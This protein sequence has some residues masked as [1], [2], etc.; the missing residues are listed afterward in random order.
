MTAEVSIDRLMSALFT[1]GPPSGIQL[2]PDSQK[3]VAWATHAAT[4]A[5]VREIG[6]D[7]AIMKA[8][9]ALI[10]TCV[11]VRSTDAYDVGQG[12]RICRALH[13]G[14]IVARVSRHPRAGTFRS[15]IEAIN[16]GRATLAQ[17]RLAGRLAAEV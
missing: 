14:W 5:L 1:F 11:A 16:R 6:D 7:E 8:T 4:V 3:I 9:C 17:M 15:L 12:E 13:R 2:D 10:R